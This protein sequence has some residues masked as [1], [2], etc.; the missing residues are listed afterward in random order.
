MVTIGDYSG[1]AKGWGWE[2]TYGSDQLRRRL[3]EATD[4]ARGGNDKK[5]DDYLVPFCR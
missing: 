1:S 3:R 5:L 4:T 2:T